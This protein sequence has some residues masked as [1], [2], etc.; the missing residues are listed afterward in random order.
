VSLARTEAPLRR[1]NNPL[2]RSGSDGDCGP[3]R[4]M[5]ACNSFSIRTLNANDAPR[6]VEMASQISGVGSKDPQQSL[7]KPLHLGAEWNGLLV[8]TVLAYYADE[9]DSSEPRA[10]A[11]MLLVAKAWH[12]QGVANLLLTQ[13]VAEVRSRFG[14]QPRI[15]V[16]DRVRRQL[17]YAEPWRQF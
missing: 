7:G 15:E 5:S 14:G 16:S 6:L 12:G 2:S 4:Q 13:L 8:A 1:I 17:T 3:Y 11:D 10:V 9:A